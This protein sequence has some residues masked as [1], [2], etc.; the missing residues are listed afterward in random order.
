VIGISDYQYARKL[1]PTRDAAAIAV[2]LADDRQG[3]YPPAHVRLRQDGEATKATLLADLASIA[4]ATDPESTVFII[5]S[6]HGGRIENGPHAGEY[7][8]PVEADPASLDSLAETYIS[9]DAFACALTD[10]IPA[11]TSLATAA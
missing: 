6:G 2:L 11:V 4:A 3:A 7:L 1:P 5:F 8:I 10:L 9:G